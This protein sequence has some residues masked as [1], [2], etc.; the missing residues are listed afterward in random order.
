MTFI[1]SP[2]L[3]FPLISFPHYSFLFLSSTSL[4]PFLFVFP[5][6]L[7]PSL[8]IPPVPGSSSSLFASLLLSFPCFTSSFLDYHFSSLFLLPLPFL[9]S[10]LFS[11]FIIS[12]F[13]TSL[14]SLLLSSPLLATLPYSSS[15]FLFLLSLFLCSLSC[16]KPLHLDSPDIS[17]PS[18]I[19]SFLVYNF[20]LL[21]ISYPSSLSICPALFFPCFSTFFFLLLSSFWPKTGK[22]WKGKRRCVVCMCS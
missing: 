17:S 20:S 19:S 8:I 4:F 18:P 21:L 2:F 15:S 9:S 5:C 22:K 7:S 13:S 11:L 3:V 16:L 1:S 12:H 10:L 14:V 6:F